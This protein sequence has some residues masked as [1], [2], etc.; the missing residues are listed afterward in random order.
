[1]GTRKL[2]SRPSGDRTASTSPAR[3]P[4][5]MVTDMYLASVAAA[6]ATGALMGL[7]VLCAEYSATSGLRQ[8]G[9]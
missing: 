3:T 4:G 9:Q 2:T 6:T 1:M 7:L 5:G 8:V